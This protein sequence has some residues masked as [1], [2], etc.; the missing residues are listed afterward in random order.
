MA[1]IWYVYKHGR[2]IF[3]VEDGL[4][5]IFG[6]MPKSKGESKAVEGLGTI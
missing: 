3:D 6:S 2:N 1:G 4:G 5:I